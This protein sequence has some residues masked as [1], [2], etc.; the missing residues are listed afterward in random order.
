MKANGRRLQGR[1]SKI[2]LF[3]MIIVNLGQS[4]ERNTSYILIL[5]FVVLFCAMMTSYIYNP[6]STIA[7]LLDHFT[8][9]AKS[10][11]SKYSVETRTSKLLTDA[12]RIY[13]ENL[14]NKINPKNET[15]GIW[16]MEDETTTYVRGNIPCAV[17]NNAKV[18]ISKAL[19]DFNMSMGYRLKFIELESLLERFFI[20]NAGNRTTVRYLSQFFV[21]E[22]DSKST[23]KLIIQWEQDTCSEGTRPSGEPRIQ[24]LHPE[25]ADLPV[26]NELNRVFVH[27]ID[28][29]YVQKPANKL[30]VLFNG[31]IGPHPSVQS[32][33]EVDGVPTL[34]Q[35]YERLKPCDQNDTLVEAGVCRNSL[36][37]ANWKE[38][39]SQEPC[40]DEATPGVW[41]RY[42]IYEQRPRAESC[43]NRYS[44]YKPEN[45][46]LF[47][48]PSHFE[49]PIFGE[50][51]S[52]SRR[53][54]DVQDIYSY[55]TGK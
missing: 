13:S 50:D 8:D 52:K 44:G 43:S 53:A 1:E 12:L 49:R 21:H 30:D 47:E 51:I 17:E 55:T 54:P 34:D 25:G 26:Y 48:H 22:V 16:T 19:E 10:F 40:N 35:R 14:P 4:M 45:R 7:T 33:I 6:D 37:I 41:D 3:S 29:D 11:F 32:P 18:V 28:S 46:V 31:R 24:F 36:H 42:G 20:S 27:S 2:I 23:R 39:P 38:E 9:R 5:L 15:I